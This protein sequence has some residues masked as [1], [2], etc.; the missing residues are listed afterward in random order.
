MYMKY[1][2]DNCDVVAENQLHDKKVCMLYCSLN[3]GA[4]LPYSIVTPFV[5]VIVNVGVILLFCTDGIHDKRQSYID[6]L[7]KD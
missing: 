6:W 4:F 1:T 7:H 3:L 5:R 2:S